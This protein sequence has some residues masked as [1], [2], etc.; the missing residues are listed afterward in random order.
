LGGADTKVPDAFLLSNEDIV[1]QPIATS[2]GY[3]TDLV[4]CRS[5]IDWLSKNKVNLP[6]DFLI[7]T[8]DPLCEI[9]QYWIK[10]Y[11]VEQGSVTGIFESRLDKQRQKHSSLYNFLRYRWQKINRK[12]LRKLYAIIKTKFK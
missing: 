5:R 7:R 8:I 9:K 11:L 2:E 12:K 6:S 1:E 10:K 4:A 3:V